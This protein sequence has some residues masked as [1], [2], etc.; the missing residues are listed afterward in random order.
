MLTESFSLGFLEEYKLKSPNV[1]LVECI[2]TFPA[3]KT[4]VNKILIL[5]FYL[6]F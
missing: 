2:T 5:P 4:I 6:Y 1:E 3:I